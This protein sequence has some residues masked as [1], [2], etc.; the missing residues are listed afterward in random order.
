MQVLRFLVVFS[1]LCRVFSFVLRPPSLAGQYNHPLRLG[2]RAFLSMAETSENRSDFM[3][4]RAIY[5][6]PTIILNPDWFKSW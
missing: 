3:S 6:T 1:A 2:R 5:G 4:I